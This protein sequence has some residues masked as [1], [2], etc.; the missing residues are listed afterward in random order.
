VLG[1]ERCG[2]KFGCNQPKNARRRGLRLILGSSCA[3]DQHLQ[4]TAD[5]IA[6]SRFSQ[7][8]TLLMAELSQSSP[9]CSR[10]RYTPDA[11]H[12]TGKKNGIFWEV[13]PG[14]PT[15]ASLSRGAALRG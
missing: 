5:C 11:T 12:N 1:G 6:G 7:D 4:S 2:K 3:P 9:Y 15:P 10:D 8:P 14:A 13:S